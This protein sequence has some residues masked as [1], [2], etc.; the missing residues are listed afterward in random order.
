[1]GFFWWEEEAAA[2]KRG[3]SPDIYEPAPT[4]NSQ[5]IWSNRRLVSQ[6]GPLPKLEREARS[7]GPLKLKMKSEEKPASFSTQDRGLSK[8]LY[9]L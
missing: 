1:M 4:S 3:F 9:R 2:L 7:E 6:L 8:F 5:Q